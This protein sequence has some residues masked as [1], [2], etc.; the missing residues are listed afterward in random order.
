MLHCYSDS[1]EM[2]I[3]AIYSP[4]GDHLK[5]KGLIEDIICCDLTKH[6]TDSFDDIGDFHN[7]TI[8][9]RPNQF[10]ESLLDLAENGVSLYVIG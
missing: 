1:D 4:N 8:I 3:I 7:D 9:I 5:L 2:Y 10:D 6:Y